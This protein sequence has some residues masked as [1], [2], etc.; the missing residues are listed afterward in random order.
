[1]A[2]MH[3]PNIFETSIF[4]MK[5]LYWTLQETTVLEEVRTCERCGTQPA[6]TITE[7][8]DPNRP[9]G[10]EKWGDDETWEMTFYKKHDFTHLFGPLCLNCIRQLWIESNG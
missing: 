7:T 6:A 8:I 10:S 9:K 3:Q 1:M 4:T 2:L 5:Y